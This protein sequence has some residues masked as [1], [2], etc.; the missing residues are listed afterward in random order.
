MKGL[1]VLIVDDEQPARRKLRSYLKKE[2][3]IDAIFEAENGIDAVSRIR[4]SHPDLVFLDI[5]MPGLNGFEVIEKV[6]IESMPAVIFVTAYD[7]YA[8]DAFEVQA[9]DYLLKPFDEERF[10]KSFSRAKAQI[11]TGSQNAAFFKNLLSEVY[12]EKKYLHRI[13]VKKGS[14]YLFVNTSE[15]SYIS[16]Y[17]KYINLHTREGTHLVRDTMNRMESRLDP[18]DFARIHRSSI[19]NLNY[20]KELQPWSHGDCIVILKDGTRLNLSRRYRDKLLGK[21]TM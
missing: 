1:D 8:L 3:G 17:E 16:A 19:V 6:G 18:D 12:K 13:M 21:K 7:E 20:V 15:I 2:A 9:V 14:R 11:Q 10:R 4:K 5:Q